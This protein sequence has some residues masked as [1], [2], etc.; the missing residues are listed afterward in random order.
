MVVALNIDKSGSFPRVAT[1]RKTKVSVGFE[2]EIPVRFNKR[3]RWGDMRAV[4][5]S[6]RSVKFIE[7]S[8]LRTH[9]ECGGVEFASPVFGNIATARKM[10][11]G[12]KRLAFREPCL[13]ENE[14]VFHSCGTHVHT[15]SPLW[16]TETS[17]KVYKQATAMLN[18]E[19]SA[20]FIYEF[21]GRSKDTSSYRSQGQ[22][23][24]WD[25]EGVTKP[26]SGQYACMRGKAMLRPNCF[27]SSNTVEYRMWHTAEDRLI[28]ALEFAHACTTFIMGRK[29][30]PYLKDFKT[31]LDKQSGYKILKQDN[32]WRLL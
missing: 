19:S 8:G 29:G 4:S 10:A 22:S 13:G 11:S 6:K 12:L 2:W 32:A 7:T 9:F 1:K 28:P 17:Y 18:R 25:T 24:C 27:G 23:T 30:I 15:S 26:S 21:S 3:D 16:N 5:Y 14:G 31:W 20:K